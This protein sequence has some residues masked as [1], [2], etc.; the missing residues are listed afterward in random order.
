MALSFE[1]Q[2]RNYVHVQNNSYG[3]GTN[4]FIDD[5]RRTVVILTNSLEEL[6]VKYYHCC[7]STR[8]P[9]VL[10]NPK[11]S[12]YK[13]TKPRYIKAWE[14]V[15]LEDWFY[16]MS[17]LAG[18]FYTE[19]SLTIITTIYTQYQTHLYNYPKQVNSQF[20]QTELSRP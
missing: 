20:S 10:N 18:L 13:E 3:K 1:L 4:S 14:Q 7:S 5:I 19:D 12:V 9:L 17:T 6:L 2:S 11:K 8:R 16:G 15:S